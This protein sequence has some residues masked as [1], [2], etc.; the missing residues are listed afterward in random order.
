M[1]GDTRTAKQIEG[2]IK[3]SLAIRAKAMININLHLKA[4]SDLRG[5]YAGEQTRIDA[6]LDELS[7]I[8]PDS[9]AALLPQRSTIPE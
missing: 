4:A 9:P 2:L 8:C 5:I 3:A 1:T 7:V 6:L